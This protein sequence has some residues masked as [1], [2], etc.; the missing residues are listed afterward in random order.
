[1]RLKNCSKISDK[2]I[3]VIIEGV[4]LLS[5]STNENVFITE[6]KFSDQI[7]GLRKFQMGIKQRVV[8]ECQNCQ[9]WVVYVTT[10]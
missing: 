8:G 3:K 10:I 2:V 7:Q 6:R 4:E 9:F 5:S 1:M